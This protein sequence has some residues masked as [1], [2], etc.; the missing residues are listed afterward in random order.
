VL[1]YLAARAPARRWPALAAAAVAIPLLFFVSARDH[2]KLLAFV[3]VVREWVAPLGYTGWFSLVADPGSFWG[4]DYVDIKV[5]S[6][7]T[8]RLV[9]IASS[10]PLLFKRYALWTALLAVLGVAALVTRRR[11]SVPDPGRGELVRMA[12]W[13]F[14]LV[15]AAQF[16]LMG[17]FT[18]QAFGY[19]GAI[20]PLLCVVL[21]VLYATVWDRFGGAPAAR[22]AMVV[23]LVACLAASPW[24]HR[25]PNLPR[26]VR[27][28]EATIPDIRRVSAELAA[29]LPAGESRIFLL[30]DPLALHL[31]GRRS[32]LRQFH[33]WWIVFTSEADASKYARAGLWG[34]AELE[35][36]LGGD[37][38]YAVVERRAEEYYRRRAPY[39][40]VMARMDALLAERFAVRRTIDTSTGDRVVVYARR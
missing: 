33:Q 40:E 1:V 23:G 15:T 17:P 2:L 7:V 19:V 27:V 16:V 9:Q 6:G 4:S 20:A 14:G 12:A 39:R 29:V 8:G 11:G 32:Y 35:R 21:G 18:K 13:L 25:H 24:V 36:W 10:V 31:A 30:G 5:G 22:A 26:R 34:R 37:A 28:A 3:P 38:R